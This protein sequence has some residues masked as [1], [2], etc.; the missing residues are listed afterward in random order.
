MREGT[1]YIF[2][3]IWYFLKILIIYIFPALIVFIGTFSILKMKKSSIKEVSWKL[4][5]QSFKYWKTTYW[6]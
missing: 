2:I 4:F 5:K 3:L 6:R 1:E